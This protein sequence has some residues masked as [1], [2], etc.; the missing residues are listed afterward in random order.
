MPKGEFGAII[1]SVFVKY[2][3]QKDIKQDESIE[4]TVKDL[5]LE[6]QAREAGDASSAEA[7]TAEAAARQEAD[8]AINAK[9][10]NQASSTNQLADKEF[11]NSSI[12]YMRAHRV[13]YNAAGA[14]F[15]TA[16]ALK[17]ATTVYHDGAEYIATEHDYC[18]IT[19]DEDAP[20]PF[21]GGQTQWEHSGTKWVYGH[22]INES[23]LTAAENA[24]LASG[25]TKAI[26]D[27]VKTFDAVPTQ[28]S[29]NPVKSGGV[30]SWFGAAVTTLTTTAKTVVGAINELVS[31]KLGKTEKAADSAKLN[32]QDASYYG[33][34]QDVSD[35]QTQAG[36]LLGVASAA[37]NVA[38][39]AYAL[40]GSK[41]P[42][43]TAT[44][45][46]GYALT[47]PEAEGGQ[48]GKVLISSLG[49][50]GGVDQVARD[51]ANAI[52]DIVLGDSLDI[53]KLSW[54]QIAAI[55]D[56]GHAD[57]IF[58]LHDEIRLTF[59]GDAFRD[60]HVVEICGFNHDDKADGSGK[61]GI[62]FCFKKIPMGSPMNSPDSTEGGFPQSFLNTLNLPWFYENLPSDLQ[63][64]IVPVIKHSR[65]YVGAG[66][67][68]P[69]NMKLFPFSVS[70]CF[71]G[72]YD[73]GN[74]GDQYPI[75]SD[76]ASR[77]RAL[78]ESYGDQPPISWWLRTIYDDDKGYYAVSETGMLQISPASTNLGVLVG[79][80]VGGT[81]GGGIFEDGILAQVNENTGAI[82]E[83]A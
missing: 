64:V 12:D 44:G 79:F 73:Y 58:K 49:G 61:A 71:G 63:A 27:S 81:G 11:V 68:S 29:A 67:V 22:G 36:A 72:S 83:T 33:A 6:A 56:S 7:I 24:A 51:M 17:A 2:D 57:K 30:W 4:A 35:L 43:I 62:T 46:P 55:A 66:G 20:A 54:A 78:D 39:N 65:V 8:N 37:R 48:P 26:I 82:K 3:T 40:A 74:E 21:T 70:E 14:Q 50:G 60:E 15:P 42:K 76:D 28:N 75:F 59:A 80:C 9:I 18:T 25:A 23:P 10:P 47:A 38:D 19:A 1:D 69:G 45:G 16:A 31:G 5:Q 77:I 32:G 52:K 13:T 34:A 53:S 41:Q